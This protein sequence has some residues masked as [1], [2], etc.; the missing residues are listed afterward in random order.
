LFL[1]RKAVTS[2]RSNGLDTLRAI[3]IL[4]VFLN[5]EAFRFGNSTLLV[6]QAVGWIGVDLFFVM[7]GYLI[8]NQVLAGVNRGE[9]LSLAAFYARRA[10]RTWP[11]YWVV[12]ACYFLFPSWMGGNTPPPL[13]RF[14]T[15]T[16]NF[17]LPT[18]TAFSHAW[19]LC[20]EEQFYLVLPLAVLLGL[21]FGRG[22]RQ[23]WHALGLLTLIG[24]TARAFLW[25]KYGPAWKGNI[26]GYYP[27]IY[28]STLCR[29][30]EFL[31]GI[32]VAILRNSYPDIWRRLMVRGR[33]LSALAAVCVS[34]AF[35]LAS[36]RFGD[37]QTGY[38]PFMTVFG[39]SI[40]ALLFAV[41]VMAALSPS[42]PISRVRIPGAYHLALWSYSIY[43]SH[44]AVGNILARV[45][46]P[47]GVSPWGLFFAVAGVSV[48]IGAL[49]YYLIEQPFIRL[50]DRWFP[51][52]FVDSS[53]A[54]TGR[55]SASS[56]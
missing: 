24:I 38:M 7:S 3:A 46:G 12:L 6:V 1:L 37:D 14:L 13:W 28:Y 56:T 43:L 25:T 35:Y 54:P 44:K 41:A 27:H 11:A 21:T 9:E 19:S 17:N 29:F 30:D 15:F 40:L 4:L 31:P 49:L 53:S 10:F 55:V 50:R 5:H 22:R 8:A 26:N 33:L 48:M 34:V 39:Y 2:A 51:Q 52:L 36:A 32:A 18:G 42:S 45:L 16:Q 20:V 47:L 23:V